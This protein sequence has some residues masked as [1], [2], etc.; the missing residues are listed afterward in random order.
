MMIV[1]IAFKKIIIKVPVDVTWFI[2][3][4]ALVEWAL[5]EGWGVLVSR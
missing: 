2:G 5:K 4:V 3:R 1:A